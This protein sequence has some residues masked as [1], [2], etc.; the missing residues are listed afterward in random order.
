M[1]LNVA[2]YTWVLFLLSYSNNGNNGTTSKPCKRN[3]STIS[4]N[5]SPISDLITWDIPIATT[6]FQVENKQTF[7]V[8]CLKVSL[9]IQI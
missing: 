3:C 1:F 5:P 2:C 8:F 9:S 6:R 4:V 7:E